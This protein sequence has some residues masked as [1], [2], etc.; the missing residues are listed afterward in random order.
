M[1]YDGHVCQVNLTDEW[2]HF[3]Q[4]EVSVRDHPDIV[5]ELGVALDDP[6]Q[7]QMDSLESKFRDLYRAYD[8]YDKLLDQYPL[9]TILW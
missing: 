9:V 4:L 1:S 8:N 6:F 3:S 2:P 7:Q 5:E